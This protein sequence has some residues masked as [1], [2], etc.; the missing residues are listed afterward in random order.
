MF[1]RYY[2]KIYSNQCYTAVFVLQQCC[3]HLCHQVDG[4]TSPFHPL[5]MITYD[6][7]VNHFDSANF[8]ASLFA[9]YK[10]WLF[11]MKV[12]QDATEWCDFGNFD[13]LTKSCNFNIV[14]DNTFTLMV[15]PPIYAV[16]NVVF[17]KQ[18]SVREAVK[19]YCKRGWDMHLLQAQGRWEDR[20]GPG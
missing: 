16:V 9:S 3:N 19:H 4:H 15:Y 7:Y 17:V 12:F 8:K 10:L 1:Y 14:V 2:S 6:P 18:D 11:W 5:W 20:G 13:A